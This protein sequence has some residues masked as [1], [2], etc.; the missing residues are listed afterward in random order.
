V[1][2]PQTGLRHK[3]QRMTELK[4]PDPARLDEL[5]A[6]TKIYGRY[7]DTSS[8]FA[9]A[10]TGAWLLGCEWVLRV[11]HPAGEVMYAAAPVAW[12]VLAASARRSYRRHGGLVPGVR[13]AFAAF[14]VVFGVFGHLRYRRV[15]RRLA[16]LKGATP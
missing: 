5:A 11:A 8:G 4:A 13:V 14:L 16:A 9:A 3:L 1:R 12:I 10:F 15:E 2:L 7:S 6:V